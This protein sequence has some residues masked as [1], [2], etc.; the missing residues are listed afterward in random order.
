M[1]RETIKM[2]YVRGFH[3]RLVLDDII[4]ETGDSGACQRRA[5]RGDNTLGIL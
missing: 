3:L 1:G 2:T 5:F 4:E